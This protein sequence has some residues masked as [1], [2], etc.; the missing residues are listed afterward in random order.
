MI[1]ETRYKLINIVQELQDLNYKLGTLIATNE[2]ECFIIPVEKRLTHY[3]LTL[4]IFLI[5]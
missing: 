2:D 3:L 4:H 1:D 5:F